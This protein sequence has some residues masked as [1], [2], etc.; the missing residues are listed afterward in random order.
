M[1]I[2]RLDYSKNKT[3]QKNCTKFR[4]N[5]NLEEFFIPTALQVPLKKLRQK[6]V[7]VYLIC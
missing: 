6:S 5:Y 7:D 4:G 1:F 2:G 3:K